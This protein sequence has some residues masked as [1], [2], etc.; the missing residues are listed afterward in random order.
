LWDIEGKVVYGIEC[1]EKL[2]SHSKRGLPETLPKVSKRQK[3]YKINLEN[4]ENH[5]KTRENKKP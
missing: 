1:F 5:K 3:H 2:K 4:I